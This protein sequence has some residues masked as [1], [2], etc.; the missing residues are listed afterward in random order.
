MWRLFAVTAT[1][2]RTRKRFRE[3]EKSA[4]RPVLLFGLACARV[5]LP[6]APMR[7]VD[8]LKYAKMRDVRCAGQVECHQALARGDTAKRHFDHHATKVQELNDGTQEMLTKYDEFVQLAQAD[9]ALN[10]HK[11]LWEKAISDFLAVAHGADME[12]D[13]DNADTPTLC[14]ELCARL[15]SGEPEH[16]THASA[17][18]LYY[19]GASV[20]DTLKVG[21]ADGDVG[22]KTNQVL[23]RKKFSVSDSSNPASDVWEV[24]SSGNPKLTNPHNLSSDGISVVPLRGAN[25]HRFG[26]IIS[27]PPA[28]PD[29][30]LES[31]ANVAGQ[32]VR[33]LATH[34]QT[35]ASS[36]CG[37]ALTRGTATPHTAT[38]R[39]LVC[40]FERVG[41]TETAKAVLGNVMF[42]I[43]KKT[44]SLNKLVYVNFDARS[45]AIRHERKPGDW[46]WQPLT[47]T[48][49]DNEKRFELP[50]CWSS[51][52]TLGLLTVECSTLTQMDEELLVLLNTLASM[53]QRAMMQIELMDLGTRPPL[54]SVQ[55]VMTDFERAQ[56][57]I[58]RLLIDQLTLNV[59]TG[60]TFSMAVAESTEYVRQLKNDKDTV[61][62]RLVTSSALHPRSAHR[63]NV[64]THACVS[65]T[66]CCVGCARALT[67]THAC[68]PHSCNS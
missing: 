43:T 4:M 59:S 1:S 35:P 15:R 29:E 17:V 57:G 44:A 12:I 39:S 3:L 23:Q 18:V 67:P 41:K 46:E 16:P 65:P 8:P 37:K 50:V 38:S 31:F 14:R 5:G 32:M 60:Q 2:V 56:T 22:L 51:G 13:D 48:A 30:F 64:S 63:P 9:L 58:A 10:E 7:I 19:H 54:D 21:H 61:S 68:A 6:C 53:V 52:Q 45:S 40:Q 28:L 55:A 62:S 24:L 25:R 34:A 42:F 20:H 47:F 26:A 11:P 49:I 33:C 27:G 36:V 66:Y